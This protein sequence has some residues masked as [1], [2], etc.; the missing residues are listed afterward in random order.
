MTTTTLQ[1]S[2]EAIT[3]ERSR[4]DRIMQVLSHISLQNYDPALITIP[5]THDDAFGEIEAVLNIL[6]E[7]FAQAKQDVSQQKGVITRQR[8]ALSE[9]STP[10][11]EIWD[12]VLTLP[13]VGLVDTQRSAEMTERLLTAVVEQKARCVIVDLT[14]VDVVDTA[15][16]DHLVRMI[17]SAQLLGA[18]CVL[19]GIGPS[20]AR[21]LVELNVDLGGVKVLRS[22][23][24]GLTECLRFLAN[25]RNKPN[26]NPG[27][28]P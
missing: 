6:T 15:T 23:K 28:T 24:E 8:I 26:A 5:L 11:I 12:D 3:I 16:A 14:G 9:L 4:L 1:A 20:I 7:E 13:V 10:I 17:K 21:T 22:L 25:S 2:T 18:L 27:A 19:T